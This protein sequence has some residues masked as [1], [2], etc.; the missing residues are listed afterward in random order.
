M[1]RIKLLRLNCRDVNDLMH[2]VF[3]FAKTDFPPSWDDSSPKVKL[4]TTF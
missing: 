1:S 4:G 3:L 2:V